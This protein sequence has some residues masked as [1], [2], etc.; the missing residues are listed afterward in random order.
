V[1]SDLS[2]NTE[3]EK[4][5]LEIAIEHRAKLAAEMNNRLSPLQVAFV[6]HFFLKQMNIGD[7][8]DATG[9]PMR[10]AHDWLEEG[11]PVSEYIAR[12][13]EKMT[14]Q[15]D[16]TME[17]I[18]MGLKAEATRMPDGKDDKTVSHAAR[19]GAWDKLARIKGGYNAGGG[20]NKSKVTVNINL[21]P[22]K[23][24]IDVEAIDMDQT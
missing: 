14:D 17:E 23:Q 11:H 16:V 5:P 10:Q 4:K 1:T 13:L 7:A 9:I 2:K 22:D 19:V 21:A 24:E 3:F 12:R 20:K 15:V 8:A 6:N 18:I